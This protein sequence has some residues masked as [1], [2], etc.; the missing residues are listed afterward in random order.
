[1]RWRTERYEYVESPIAIDLLGGG[2]E[3]RREI[4][5]GASLS[6]IQERWDEQVQPFASAR[7]DFLIYTN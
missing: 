7:Q 3:L 6:A 5:S 2:E 1:M 4:E